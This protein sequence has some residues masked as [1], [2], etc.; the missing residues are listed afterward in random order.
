MKKKETICVACRK[1]VRQQDSL[2]VRLDTVTRR[3]ADSETS[4]HVRQ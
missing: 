2:T 4:R 1:A 3:Q